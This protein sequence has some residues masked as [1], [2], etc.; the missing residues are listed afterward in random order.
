MLLQTFRS[1]RVQVIEIE[2][3]AFV[4]TN[5]LHGEMVYRALSSNRQSVDM[6]MPTIYTTK[7]IISK[8]LINSMPAFRMMGEKDHSCTRLKL[9]EA[10]MRKT[11][12]C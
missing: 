7:K 3:G 1:S 9:R 2:E 6:A 4:A 10:M 11:M 5:A 12:R 8:L